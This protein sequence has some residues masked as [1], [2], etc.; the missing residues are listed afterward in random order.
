MTTKFDG[1]WVMMFRILF[2]AMLANTFCFFVT[3]ASFAASMNAKE[4]VKKVKKKYDGL[5]SLQADFEQIFRWELAGETQTVKGTIYLKS[6]NNYRIETDDQAIITNGTTVWTYSKPNEQVIIDLL[7]KADENPLPKDLLF[8]YAEDY[9]ATL[10]GEEKLDGQ[11][12]Y[13]LSLLPKDEEAFITSMK[14]WV[15]ASNW[16]TRKIEQIDINENVNTYFVRNIQENIELNDTLFEFDIPD[17]IEVVD[18]RE[19]D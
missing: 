3:G 4:I 10:V 12:T 19:S 18:L 13:V 11:K 16:F 17:A 8:Q 6:G 5:Q 15:D 14:I 9:N 2:L 1:E 7:N